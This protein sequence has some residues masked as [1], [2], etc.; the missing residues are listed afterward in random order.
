M[1]DLTDTDWGWHTDHKIFSTHLRVNEE[2]M[3]KINLGEKSTVAYK[4]KR[5]SH[6]PKSEISYVPG[7]KEEVK[8]TEV[9][10]CSLSG[11]SA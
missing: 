9:T 1:S 5:V 7:R 10:Q 8:P 2:W 3:S 4:I 6:H 11:R